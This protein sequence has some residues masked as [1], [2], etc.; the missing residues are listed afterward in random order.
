M[1]ASSPFILVFLSHP[2]TFRPL[3]HVAVLYRPRSCVPVCFYVL[4][5]ARLVIIGVLV[6]W[7]CGGGGGDER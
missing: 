4:Q 2:G 6:V 1:S 7:C 3:P 5:C